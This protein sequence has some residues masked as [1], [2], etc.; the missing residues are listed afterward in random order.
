V[1]AQQD[2]GGLIVGRWRFSIVKRAGLVAALVLVSGVLPTGVIAADAEA[3]TGSIAGV[4]WS[5]SD[6]NGLRSEAEAGVPQIAVSLLGAPD[7]SGDGAELAT[8]TTATD[9]TY[10]FSDVQPGEYE[11]AFRLSED[12]A[13]TY[14]DAGDDDT[15]DSDPDPLTG[16]TMPISIGDE[17]VTG[18]DAGLLLAAETV[19]IGGRVW[20]DWNDD[21]IQQ[22]ANERLL[23]DVTVTLQKEKPAKKRRGKRKRKGTRKPQ[24][25]NVHAVQSSRINGYEFFIRPNGGRYRVVIERPVGYERSDKDQGGSDLIDSDVD[26]DTGRSALVRGRSSRELDAGLVPLSTIGDRVWLDGNGNGLQDEDEPGL[27]NALVSLVNV[28]KA[29]GLFD[30][31]QAWTDADGMYAFQGVRPGTYGLYFSPVGDP[32]PTLFRVGDDPGLDSDV[33]DGWHVVPDFEVPDDLLTPEAQA[34]RRALAGWMRTARRLGGVSRGDPDISAGPP[35]VGPSS[36][37][38]DLDGLFNQW[39]DGGFLTDPG[40]GL[41][42]PES[43]QEPTVCDTGST[44]KDNEVV[45]SGVT[46]TVGPNGEQALVVRMKKGLTKDFSFAVI[47]SVRTPD[48]A[49]NFVWELHDGELKVGQLDADTGEIIRENGDGFRII[50]ERDVGILRFLFG[51]GI[52]PADAD[53]G[54]VRSFQRC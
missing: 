37:D 12:W 17:P 43:A 44:T 36:A 13:P 32:K 31:T 34:A 19:L 40:S 2:P 20:E 41:V 33:S 25:E 38:L 54:L 50:H 48:G 22:P 39:F 27:F 14:Q 7:A 49:L 18:V 5:D 15:V 30:T 53:L 47:F 4:V 24:Y 42:I 9:G 8:Q 35:G 52:I 6:V 21:G 3:A 23:A 46:W 1:G 16:R 45:V 10:T 28:D 11:V 51:P 26:V 29:T